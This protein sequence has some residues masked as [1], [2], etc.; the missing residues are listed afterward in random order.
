MEREF[1][2]LPWQ[3]LLFLRQAKPDEKPVEPPPVPEKR[4]GEQIPKPGVEESQE[5][6][7]KRVPEGK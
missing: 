3:H 4:E 5:S 6:G 2:G 7:G 1:H